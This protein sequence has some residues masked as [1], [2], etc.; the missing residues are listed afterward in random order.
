[1]APTQAL[2]V[3]PTA[4]LTPL[5]PT[6]TP[7][8][9]GTPPVRPD[10]V[11]TLSGSTASAEPTDAVAAEL[12]LLARRRVSQEQNIAIGRVRLVEVQPYQWPDSSLGCPVSG[13]SYVS[14]SAAGYRILL[15][16]NTIRYAFHTDFDRIIA[17][18]EGSEVLPESES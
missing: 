14:V 18:E 11:S 6:L 8:A 1:M 17:C 10:A 5:P 15:E 3:P 13:E 12:V 4:T 2:V 9:T 7:T 16:A